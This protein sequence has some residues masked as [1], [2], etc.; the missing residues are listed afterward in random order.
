[1]VD[2]P[3][4]R[5]LEFQRPFRLDDMHPGD[6]LSIRLEVGPQFVPEPLNVNPAPTQQ[7]T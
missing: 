3:L 6:A 7:V 1:V 4:N 5:T 2:T